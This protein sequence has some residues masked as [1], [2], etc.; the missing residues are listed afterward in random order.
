[1]VAK[2]ETPYICSQADRNEAGN[3][4]ISAEKGQVDIR[5]ATPLLLCD[6]R[7]SGAQIDIV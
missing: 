2:G 5:T 6:G 1:M 7:I 4:E 3:A